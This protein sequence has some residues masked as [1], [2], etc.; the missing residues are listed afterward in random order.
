MC[1]NM[2]LPLPAVWQ[3]VALGE[4]AE[5][6]IMCI[7]NGQHPFHVLVAT[8][9]NFMLLDSRQP[10]EP[11]LTLLHHLAWPPVSMTLIR[12][13]K[14]TSIHKNALNP[15]SIMQAFS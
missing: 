1:Y 3:A 15:S 5:D 9:T 14:N 12:T 7:G 11:L 10:A 2:Q 4:G 8:R 13:A 6:E